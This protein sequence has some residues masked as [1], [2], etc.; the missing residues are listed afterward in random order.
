M[1]HLSHGVP[2]SLDISTPSADFVIPIS[3]DESCRRIDFQENCRK[4]EI[5][6]YYH[7]CSPTPLS[8][9][10]MRPNPVFAHSMIHQRFVCDCRVAHC[11]FKQSSAQLVRGSSMF[12][13]PSEDRA[14]RPPHMWRLIECAGRMSKL[15]WTVLH[16]SDTV[17]MSP[18]FGFRRWSKRW[19]CLGRITLRN[20]WRT[21]YQ[22]SW[23][24]K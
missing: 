24:A 11:S 15:P 17:R 8:T 7:I 5:S 6:N 3:S 22:Q 10:Q 12:S 19:N 14:R 2:I 23:D 13:Q 1:T 4:V 20:H 16:C 9:K 18:D 21:E